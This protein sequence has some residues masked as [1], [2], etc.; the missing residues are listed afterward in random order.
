VIMELSP[1]GDGSIAL[2]K[3]MSALDAEMRL[4]K[5]E[6]REGS[7]ILK[8][9]NE[10]AKSII[11][12][13]YDIHRAGLAYRD[14]KP[15]NILLMEHYIPKL[16]DL[17]FATDEVSSSLLVGT[18]GYMAPEIFGAAIGQGPYNPKGVDL[19]ALG[20]MLFKL[21]TGR[22]VIN[23]PADLTKDI[24]R[25][26]ESKAK[27]IVET[28]IKSVF[29]RYQAEMKGQVKIHL[30]KLGYE[31][32]SAIKGDTLEEVALMLLCYDP[33]GRLDL[34][35]VVDSKGAIDLPNFGSTNVNNFEQI[36][37]DGGEYERVFSTI[38]VD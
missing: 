13:L 28:D 20:V 31:N 9:V 17:D 2:N 27:G 23:L 8:L 24:N 12:G 36:E 3:L 4:G 10:Y 11:I 34:S 33:A 22:Q 21:A 26:L 5:G 35:L 1:Y 6:V 15:A 32:H 37:L 18:P 25:V 14:L 30:K 16:M 7:D 29:E 19:W 38:Y